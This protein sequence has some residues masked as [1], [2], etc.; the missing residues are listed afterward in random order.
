MWG[1]E[2]RGTATANRTVNTNLKEESNG[3]HYAK[4][5]GLYAKRGQALC[6]LPAEEVAVTLVVGLADD[7]WTM[8]EHGGTAQGVLLMIEEKGRIDALATVEHLEMEMVAGSV[9]GG[10]GE[11]NHLSGFDMLPGVH[12]VDRLMTIERL[13]AVGV[14]HH[15]AVAIT[16]NWARLLDDTV[17][18]YVDTVVWRVGFD[19]HAGMMIGGRGVRFHA[20]LVIR[21]GDIA[22][23]ERVA[24]VLRIE[25]LQVDLCRSCRSEVLWLHGIE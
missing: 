5:G 25:K 24:P 22:A 17:K 15:D 10:T 23:D 11:S 18:G 16:G 14:F 1:G 12:E 9:A 6:D 4:K 13:N 3:G 8:Q 20:Q 2:G 21:T 19:V 7:L